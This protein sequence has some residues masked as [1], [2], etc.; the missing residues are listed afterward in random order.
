[1]TAHA[2][3]WNQR[4]K[5]ACLIII[6]CSWGMIKQQ[7]IIAARDQQL[8]DKPKIETRVQTQTIQGPVRVV[9][10]IVTVPGG[11]RIVERVITRDA[12]T[13]DS[14]VASVETPVC[15]KPYTPRFFIGASANPL[16]SQDGQMIR[17]GY[18]VNGRLDI[19][20]GHSINAAEEKHEISTRFRF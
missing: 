13:T 14:R 20:Y 4:F 3:V 18:T 16:R 2:L 1:M 6:A 9:E 7:T 15:S 19:G 17:F 5:I 8:R 10:K 12:V 11:E